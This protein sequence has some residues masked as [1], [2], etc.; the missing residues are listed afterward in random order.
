MTSAFE[1]YKSKVVL[2]KQTTKVDLGSSGPHVKVD[3]CLK[4][5]KGVPAAGRGWVQPEPRAQAVR[6]HCGLCVRY[7][8]PQR[9]QN[10]VIWGGTTFLVRCRRKVVVQKLLLGCFWVGWTFFH[11]K[12]CH[13]SAGLIK[14]GAGPI[15]K[16]V[17]RSV[18]KSN[19]PGKMRNDL[20]NSSEL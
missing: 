3:T 7:K 2:K 11:H 16:K 1:L 5:D 13:R 14:N 4:T 19:T 12:L 18:E 9:Q 20:F 6:R 10:F 17:Q 8:V 15:E